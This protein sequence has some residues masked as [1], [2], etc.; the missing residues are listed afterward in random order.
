MLNDIDM[1]VS[2][3]F[4]PIGNAN[5]RTFRGN[6]NGGGHIISNLTIY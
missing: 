1:S 3:T 4:T 5:N 6:F 2:G